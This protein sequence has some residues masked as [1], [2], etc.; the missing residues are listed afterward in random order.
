M[1]SGYVITVLD[2][3]GKYVHASINVETDCTFGL[4]G[5]RCYLR[6]ERS[7]A[8]VRAIERRMGAHHCVM[9]RAFF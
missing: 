8:A 5:T 6:Y 3:Q 7:S 1:A 9:S 4:K 2:C